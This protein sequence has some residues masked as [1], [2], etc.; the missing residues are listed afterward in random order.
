MST[1]N[2]SILPTVVVLLP[3]L[4]FLGADIGDAAVIRIRGSAQ[5]DSTMVTLED[6][7]DISDPDPKTVERLKRL[8]LAPAPAAGRELRLDFATIRSRLIALGVNAADID[9]SGNSVVTVSVGEGEPGRLKRPQSS[10]SKERKQAETLIAQVV[11]LYLQARVPELGKVQP[12][13]RIDPADVQRILAGA[14]SGFEIRGGGSPWEAPQQ[15]TLRFLDARN[16]LHEVAVQCRLKL[17]PIILAVKYD[18][19]AGYV[20]RQADLER[21][22]ADSRTNGVSNVQE[23][24]GKETRRPIRSGRPIRAADVRAIPLVRSGDVVTVYS[25]VGRI[26]V[27]THMRSQSGG[28]MG[29]SVLVV[30][31]DRKRKL[32]ATVVG[33]REVEVARSTRPLSNGR[34]TEDGGV[35]FRTAPQSIRR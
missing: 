8:A 23:L 2:R 29:D 11:Q 12:S 1:R 14:K 26:T 5:V 35:Q 6:V 33:Y 3:T 25:R 9:F 22:H 7:A 16:V 18:V 13:V 27:R 17:R 15:F 28:G 20:I 10:T 31:P 30:S 34:R 19:P 24:V 21:R 4:L 32:Q